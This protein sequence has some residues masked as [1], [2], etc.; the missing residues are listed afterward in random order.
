MA[1]AMQPMRVGLLGMGTVGRGTWDVLNRNAEEIARRAGRPIRVTR[2]GTR[3][4]QR[5][6]AALTAAPDVRV[7]TDLASVV[8]SAQSLRRATGSRRK[9]FESKSLLMPA[10]WP[11]IA[12]CR[13]RPARRGP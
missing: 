10:N 8:T 12:A 6:S 11:A 2:I 9:F 13:T 1:I 3:T 7:S 5:A 4:P